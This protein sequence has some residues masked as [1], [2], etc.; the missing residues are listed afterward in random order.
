M[1]AQR[2]DDRGQALYTGESQRSN[3]TYSY[4][5]TDSAGKRRFIYAETLQDLREKEKE[6]QRNVLDGIDTYLAGEATLNYMFDRYISSKLDL[7]SHTRENYKIMYR[8]Y[9]KD[10]IGN[11]KIADIKFSDMVFFYQYLLNEKGMLLNSVKGVHTVLHP[12]FEMAV[13]DDIIEENPCA[14]AMVAA[15]Q[16]PGRN[17][18]VRHALTLEQQRSFMNFVENT[19]K[20]RHWL[21]LFTVL[22]GT[23]MRIGEVVG[24]RWEDINLDEQTIDVN[25]ALVYYPEEGAETT[26]SV[27]HVSTTKTEAGAR[28]IPMTP[29]V[30]AAFVEEM[31]RQK[32][33]GRNT[34]VVDGMSGFFFSNRFRD[35]HNPQS[36]NRTI[37][38]IVSDHNLEEMKRAKR[39]GRKPVILPY[40]SCHIF[41]HTFCTRFC[42]HESDLKVIQAIMGHADVETTMQV[43]AEIS[44]MRKKE[45]FQMASEIDGIF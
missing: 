19:P 40:F 42:E 43:Y 25:H 8:T 23:G 45:A 35:V 6:I 2:K 34:R 20:F 28:I 24:L 17:H 31:E 36:I 44:E 3:R 33:T 7:K 32:K 41:R 18:G 5:Y 22:L 27:M 21:P 16:R 38:R 11:K 1:A 15:S 4:N 9:V 30:K 10:V 12:T 37:K 39:E 29:R 26:K 13:R 14:G